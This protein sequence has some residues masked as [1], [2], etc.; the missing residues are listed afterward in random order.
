MNR[1]ERLL[2][3]LTR[4]EL[5]GHTDFADDSSFYLKAHPFD[6]A[7]KEIPLGLYELPRR[8]GDAHFYRLGHPLAKAVIAQAKDRELPYSEIVF[9]LTNHPTRVSALDAFKGQSGVLQVC[10]LGVEALD[11]AEDHLIVSAIQ[12]DGSVLDEDVAKKL[13]TLSASSIQEIKE[14]PDH[15]KLSA[16]GAAR[17]K[18]IQEKINHRNAAFFEAEAAKLDDWTEDLKLGLEREMKELDRQ[19][20]EARRSMREAAALED[21]VTFQKQ[22]KSL[23]AQRNLKRKNLYEAQDSLEQPRDAINI[24]IEG[25]LTHK[26]SL[27]PLFTVRWSVV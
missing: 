9:D 11:Q 19:I 12:G 3:E 10:H 5:D 26:V 2:I 13:L 7:T 8:Y 15:A 20:K 21:K 4:H 14:K 18:A 16:T 17:Q 27:E 23:E 25:K 24:S 1:Y 22:L 6:K